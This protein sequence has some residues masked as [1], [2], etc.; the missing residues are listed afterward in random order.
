[1]NWFLN[2]RISAKLL[3]SFLSLTALTSI[4]GIVGIRDLAD[5]EGFNRAR[6]STTLSM[7]AALRG[8]APRSAPKRKTD[9]NS[10][11]GSGHAG[12]AEPSVSAKGVPTRAGAPA[13]VADDDLDGS[14]EEM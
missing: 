1:M 13:T 9:G 3:L 8:E 6:Q 7:G 5:G 10:K 2:M 11:G 4:V 12:S 14:F